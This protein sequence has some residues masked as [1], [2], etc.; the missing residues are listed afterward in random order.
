MSNAE[1]NGLDA[2]DIDVK[3]LND[4]YGFDRKLANELIKDIMKGNFESEKS[5]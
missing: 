5:K 1:D 3:F 4:K 2:Y